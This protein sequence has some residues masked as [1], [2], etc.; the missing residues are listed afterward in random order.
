MTSAPPSSTGRPEHSDALWAG[1][2]PEQALAAVASRLGLD[3][4]RATLV[5]SDANAI[6][7]LDDLALRVTPPA[8]ASTKRLHAI[9]ASVVTRAA[10]GTCLQPRLDIADEPIGT[11]HGT[12][13]VWPW[14]ETSRPAT[15]AEMGPLLKRF[16]AATRVGPLALPE[17]NPLG[18][19]ANRIDLYAGSASADPTHVEL[20]RRRQG[21]VEQGL[22]KVRWSMPWGVIH[23]HVTPSNV[24]VGPDGPQFIDLDQMALGPR[25]WDLAL[26][27]LYV[28]D[29]G[30]HPREYEQFALGYG[31]DVRDLDCCADLVA[32]R[33]LS[34]AASLAAR[35]TT[36][37]TLA[38]PFSRFM[39]L[40]AKR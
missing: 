6:Y 16:H 40:L 21:A 15:W 27:V 34:Y 17:W 25:E 29:Y 28:E 18:R 36:S 23:G 12:V 19:A 22:S 32:A 8:T 20:L 11:D 5:A 38:E 13:T 14:V 1:K 2:V 37:S 39:T 24:L 7:R 4:D 33:E 30:L 10:D 35:S 31:T 26:G 9:F 3:T